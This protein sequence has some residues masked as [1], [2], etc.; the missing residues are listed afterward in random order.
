MNKV[1][2]R[3]IYFHL[4]SILRG[5]RL[6]INDACLVFQVTP[7]ELLEAMETIDSWCVSRG[8]VPPTPIVNR[9]GKNQT[10]STD[11]VFSVVAKSGS[12]LYLPLR[13]FIPEA[14]KISTNGALEFT[15][16]AEEGRGFYGNIKLLLPASAKPTPGTGG[17]FVPDLEKAREFYHGLGDI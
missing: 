10:M 3:D 12:R 15:L 11:C 2:V 6:S 16:R 9:H 14:A 1:L 17:I 4:I 7:S 13:N 8:A 5:E